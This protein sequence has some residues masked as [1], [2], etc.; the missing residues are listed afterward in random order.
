MGHHAP[1]SLNAAFPGSGRLGSRSRAQGVGGHRRA[2]MEGETD[3]G[4]SGAPWRRHS[5]GGAGRRALAVSGRPA[6]RPERR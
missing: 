3:A 6:G 5:P 4:C 1:E 2:G